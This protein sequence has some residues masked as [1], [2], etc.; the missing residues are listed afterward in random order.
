MCLDV[1]KQG[2]EDGQQCHR[3]IVDALSDALH[4]R[5]RLHELPQF[6]HLQQLLQVLRCVLKES[7]KPGFDQLWARLHDCS[8]TGDEHKGCA[9][10]K[11]TGW[12]W[13]SLY[14]DDNVC[15]PGVEWV[16]EDVQA[17]HHHCRVTSCKRN[18]YC[19]S[20]EKQRGTGASRK[21]QCKPYQ[22]EKSCVWQ[23]LPAYRT[24]W[25]IQGQDRKY[26]KLQREQRQE[27]RKWG[28]KKKGPYT[29]QKTKQKNRLHVL[30]F[31]H[32]QS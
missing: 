4:L 14:A 28:I 31:I 18:I 19:M 23:E 15:L 25:E 27:R 5:T 6:E 16:C 17:A 30:G 8:K 7:P 20:E 1:L 2:S 13:A 12:I 9:L 21:W 24:G 10:H 11:T 26:Q 29:W 3:H 32:E 22:R